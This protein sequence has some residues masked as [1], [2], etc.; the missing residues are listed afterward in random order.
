MQLGKWKCFIFSLVLKLKVILL[1]R[2]SAFFFEHGMK[3]YQSLPMPLIC[4]VHNELIYMY[5][6]TE[7]LFPNAI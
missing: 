1:S 5:T 6:E 4:L 3:L 2:H 7:A